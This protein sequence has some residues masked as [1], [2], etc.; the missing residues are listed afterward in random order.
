MGEGGII[1]LRRERLRIPALT[2]HVATRKT[3]Y[4]EGPWLQD[5]MV[6]KYGYIP[7]ARVQDGWIHARGG[8]GSISVVVSL[9]FAVTYLLIEYYDGT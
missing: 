5:G 4:L 1:P 2:I 6:V 7:H 8:D 9:T 3:G